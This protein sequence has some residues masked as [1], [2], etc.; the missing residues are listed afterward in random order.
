[1]TVELKTPPKSK[2]TSWLKHHGRYVMALSQP[3][4]G[5]DP[6]P[7][8]RLTHLLT[9][10][11]QCPDW[12]TYGLPPRHPNWLAHCPSPGCT[13]TSCDTWKGSFSRSPCMGISHVNGVE[14]KGLLTRV[15]GSS[16][17]GAIMAIWA[18]DILDPTYK[19]SSFQTLFIFFNCLIPN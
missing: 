18:I 1:M 7:V 19:V 16:R 11:P 17:N 2:Y 6:S 12:L 14:N 4:R 15:N 9:A 3:Q 5:Y 8:P 10:P 13:H